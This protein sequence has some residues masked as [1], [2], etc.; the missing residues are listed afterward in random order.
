MNRWIGADEVHRRMAFGPLIETMRAVFGAPAGTPQR[1]VYRLDADTRDAFAV[2]PA[3][4]ADVACVKVFTYLPDNAVAGRDV[5][6]AQVLLFDRTTG[7]PLCVLDGP[8]ITQ[9]RTAAMAGLA[10]DYLARADVRRLVVCGTG[11]LAPFMALAHAA[12]RPIE[13]VGI[14]GRNAERAAR[15]AASVRARRPDLAVDV[16]TD[17]AAASRAAD[18]VSCATAS[19]EPIV[20]G[21]WIRPGTH[22]DLFG[23]H[24]RDARECD[25]VLVEKSR[26]YVDSRVNV[27]NEAGELLIP[28]AEG[29]FDA[30]DVVAELAELC[31]GARPGRGGPDEITLFKSVGTA[32]ADLAAAWHLARG[33]SDPAGGAAA[34]A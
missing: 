14:W 5:L 16:V 31:S 30:G 25:G 34:S 8:S 6:H 28:I 19:L 7:A 15:T 1:Q 32:L 4:N 12:V 21:D 11:G 33:D 9:W 2:L 24:E 26:V 10:A 18:V 23:N 17:L 22:V 13:H 29:R 20:H 3:W 27:L